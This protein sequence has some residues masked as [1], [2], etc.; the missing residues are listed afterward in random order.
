MAVPR[1][2]RSISTTQAVDEFLDT[3]PA[4]VREENMHQLQVFL[5]WYGHD[6][7]LKELKPD[8][9]SAFTRKFGPQAANPVKRLAVL[10][11]FLTFAR[12]QGYATRDLTGSVHIANESAASR[13]QTARPAGMG[14]VRLTPEG[15]TQLKTELEA[16]KAQRPETTRELDDV[17]TSSMTKDTMEVDS[18]Q[19]YRTLLESHIGDLESVLRRTEVLCDEEVPEGRVG[20]GSIVVLRDLDTG[21]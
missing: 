7:P 6:R 16:L 3:V 17:R 20:L 11:T 10:R 13:Q 5:D 19:H 14:V 1:R 4:L 2:V 12:T 8:L 9:V 18:V 21:R 15:Y